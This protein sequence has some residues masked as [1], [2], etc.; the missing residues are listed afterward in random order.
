[1]L[2]RGEDRYGYYE[3]E[4]PPESDGG[5]VAIANHERGVELYRGKEQELG[6][7]TV[8]RFD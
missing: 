6:K 4:V 3:H 8:A 7:E 2:V 1:L 5:D